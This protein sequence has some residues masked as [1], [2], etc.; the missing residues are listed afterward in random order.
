MEI[1]YLHYV[2]KGVN[3]K[4]SRPVTLAFVVETTPT[5]ADRKEATVSFARCGK[6]DQFCRKEGRTIASDRLRSHDGVFSVSF[7]FNEDN[8]NLRKALYAIAKK[9]SRNAHHYHQRRERRQPAS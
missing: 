2:P 9:V 1:R 7:R 4:K 6:G 8:V 3:P 5:R